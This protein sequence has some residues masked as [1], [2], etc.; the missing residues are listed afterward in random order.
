MFLINIFLSLL[1]GNNCL[2]IF[3]QLKQIP[4][5]TNIKMK[6]I[7]RSLCVSYVWF[8]GLLAGNNCLSFFSQLKQI[9]VYTNIKMKLITRSLCCLILTS[10]S[11]LLA[12]NNCLSTFFQL[13]QTTRVKLI[14]KVLGLEV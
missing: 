7:T 5:Y 4:V 13:K 1:A 12:G 3:S 10:S 14:R 8:F 6:L 2:S 9:P 11:S